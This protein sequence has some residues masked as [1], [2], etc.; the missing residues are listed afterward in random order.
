MSTLSSKVTSDSAGPD[1]KQKPQNKPQSQSLP[2]PPVIAIVVGEHSGDTLGEGLM[3]AI[4]EKQPNA[5]FIGIGGPKMNALGFESLYAM[6]ELAVMGIV[7][8]LGR[9]RRLLHIRKSLTEYFTQ[10]KPDVF[11]GIDAPDFNLTLEQRL[12]AAGIKTVH[13]VSPSV[14]AWREKRVFKVQAATNLVLALL[15]FEKAF[16]DKYQV[17]CQFV[18]HS[19]ADDIPLVSDKA[20][21][22]EELEL[23]QT[24]KVLAL[25]PG[26]R[27]GELSRL[28][29]PFLLSAKQLLAEDPALTFVV[30][31]ISEKRAEQ[32]NALHQEI[33][34][35]LPIKLFI[36]KTQAVMAASDCLLTASGTVTLEAALIKR[37]M[38]ITY[39]FNWLT[40]Q[41]GKIMVKL[42]H[43][44][45][46]NLLAD[47]ALVP[48]LLQ[49]DVTPENIVPLLKERLY[50]DQSSLNQAFTDIHLTLKQ[51]A[52]QQAA[53]AVF[54]LMQA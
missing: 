7:E 9:I 10:N 44:S 36:G 21:A 6:D 8:V 42:K 38:V 50:Q 29:E 15:P 16:Y 27:G 2:N 12:K 34:P 37:P 17:P 52:S 45:L 46:P 49:D 31:M 5:K 53:K 4:L 3:K 48:E 19:L 18:G 35:E 47:K 54:E 24:G 41:M 33:V 11:I 25:M 26:S 22:R 32:F 20:A 28:V 39:R 14:W 43:F 13:Y 30:P 40:Y 1:S 23:E 51:D